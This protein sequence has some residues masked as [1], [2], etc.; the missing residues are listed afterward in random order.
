MF[1]HKVLSTTV[2]RSPT[3]SS[4]LV[5]LIAESLYQLLFPHPHPSP[6]QPPF[7]FYDFDFFFLFLKIPCISD[8]VQYLSFS[9]CLISLSI[10][11]SRAKIW[12]NIF[13]TDTNLTVIFE[14]WIP[15]FA[16]KDI[17]FLKSDGKKD[18]KCISELHRQKRITELQNLG[19][20]RV[21]SKLGKTVIRQKPGSK[22]SPDCSE[23][24]NHHFWITVNREL[25]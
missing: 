1:N 17:L 6:W 2:T 22:G 19:W 8:T 14:I 11:P 15:I 4:E 24:R 10:V 21:A 5:H 13:N 9:A 18:L 23:G 20:V 25:K 16:E 12:W 3:R 7:C